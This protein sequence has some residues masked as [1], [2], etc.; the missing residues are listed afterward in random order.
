MPAATVTI[1]ILRERCKKC[2][3]C[4]RA[5]TAFDGVF[6]EGPD[7]YPVVARPEECIQC[8]ICHTVCPTNAIVHENHRV[9]MLVNP[10]EAIIE[11]YR[12]MV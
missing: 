9:A 7:G 4:V 11:R 1:R 10:D 6:E 8:L 3:N 12:S 5:C 2:L